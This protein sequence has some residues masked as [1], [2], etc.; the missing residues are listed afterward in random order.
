[1][2]QQASDYGIMPCAYADYAY[3]IKLYMYVRDMNVQKPSSNI[4][5]FIYIF[6]NALQ[7]SADTKACVRVRLR[8]FF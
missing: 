8:L 3:L 1:M 2:S 6:S 4:S 5:E 7:G